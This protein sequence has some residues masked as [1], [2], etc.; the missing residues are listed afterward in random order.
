MI[1]KHTIV[2]NV[3]LEPR[4]MFTNASNTKFATIRVLTSESRKVDG[5]WVEETVG[6]NVVLWERLA[7]QVEN[8]VKVGTL[9][10]VEGPS[11]T[12]KYQDSSGKDRYITEIT[13]RTMKVLARRK[14]GQECPAEAEPQENMGDDVPF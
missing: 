2:G 3:G 6:H 8:Q 14:E 12:R 7:E 11:K 9:L 5:E 13:A 1:N 4:V 10:Y